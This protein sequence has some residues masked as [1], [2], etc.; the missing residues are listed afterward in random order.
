[1]LLKPRQAALLVTVAVCAAL[2]MGCASTPPEGKGQKKGE[3]QPPLKPTAADTA[4]FEEKVEYAYPAVVVNRKINL[5]S[6]PGTPYAVV[7]TLS[8]GQTVTVVAS[9]GEWVKVLV[10]RD[11]RMGWVHKSLI[12]R[13]K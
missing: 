3:A 13:K 6:G 8:G 10:D 9:S 5:R 7:G 4:A 12:R 11:D 2:W 1:M